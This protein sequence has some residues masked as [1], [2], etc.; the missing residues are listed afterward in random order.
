MAAFFRKLVLFIEKMDRKTRNFGAQLYL[1]LD[2]LESVSVVLKLICSPKQF[3]RTKPSD[4]KL[5]SYINCLLV[6]L[7]LVI[8]ILFFGVR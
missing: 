1:F 3:A 8:K 5:F 2:P 6:F 4:L 7:V